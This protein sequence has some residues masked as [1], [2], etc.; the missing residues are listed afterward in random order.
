MKAT[1]MAIIDGYDL[2]YTDEEAA[3]IEQDPIRLTLAGHT[4]AGKTEWLT[5]LLDKPF[6]ERSPLPDTTKWEAPDNVRLPGRTEPYIKIYDVPGQQ[7]SGDV[8]LRAHEA[9]GRYPSPSQMQQFIDSNLHDNDEHAAD[10]KL[11]SHFRTCDVIL[12]LADCKA[13]PTPS[14]LDEF[15]LIQR[16]GLPVIGILNFTAE[17]TSEGQGNVDRWREALM[18]EGAR[19]VVRFDA[20]DM[21]P[22]AIQ[23]LGRYLVELVADSPLKGKFMNYYWQRTIV[24][25]AQFRLNSAVG[26]VA[27]FLVNAATYRRWHRLTV[28][29]NEREVSR[30]MSASA[31]ELAHEKAKVLES[32]IVG[33]FRHEKPIAVGLSPDPDTR[34]EHSSGLFRLSSGMVLLRG[35][36]L[37][38]VTGGL[39]AGLVSGGLGAPA[40]AAIGGAIGAIID[41]TLTVRVRKTKYRNL[42][43]ILEVQLDQKSLQAK[44]REYLALIDALQRRGFG[45]AGPLDL[46]KSQK[47]LSG[48]DNTTKALSAI[49]RKRSWSQWDKPGAQARQ[50]TDMVN[51]LSRLLKDS[52]EYAAEHDLIPNKLAVVKMS[53][54]T[55][56][57]KVYHSLSERMSG[58][59]PWRAQ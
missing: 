29:E 4:C 57:T 13:G 51:T 58:R 33:C 35:A 6:G 30:M 53:A 7:F 21:D 1:D 8:L 15:H 55:T 54:E 12:F 45:C 49:R 17:Q 32:G 37:G 46:G 41:R 40:G 26:L 27:E 23:E 28:D 16:L 2:S 5:S 56:V 20:F 10:L 31:R 24:E 14:N 36:S 44:C 43:V 52:L 50:R 3:T 18:L 22:R 48:M 11:L 42:G 38:A 25:P 47:R 19:K 39:L 59:R 9:F 34:D